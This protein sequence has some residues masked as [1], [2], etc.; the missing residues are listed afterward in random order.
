MREGGY[1]F[2]GVIVHCGADDE[3]SYFPLEGFPTS[4][5]FSTMCSVDLYKPRLTFED[6]TTPF[7][8]YLSSD[9]YGHETRLFCR[10]ED[11]KSNSIINYFRAQLRLQL[12]GDS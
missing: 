9:E 12:L 8:M 10:V 5:S 2:R 7:M 3:F 11:S 4:G 1:S 6:R